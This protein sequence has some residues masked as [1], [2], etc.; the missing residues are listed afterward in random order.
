[1]GVGVAV[2]GVG[3]DAV[4]AFGCAGVGRGGVRVRL[5]GMGGVQL[6]LRDVGCATNILG[7]GACNLYSGMWGVQLIFRDVGCATNIPGCGVCRCAGCGA[8]RGVVTRVEA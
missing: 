4:R 3:C 6:I 1:M 8:V 5:C 2:L 7:C